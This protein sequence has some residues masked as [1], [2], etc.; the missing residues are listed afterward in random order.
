MVEGT[1]CSAVVAATFSVV[2]FVVGF[3]TPYWTLAEEVMTGIFYR[4]TTLNEGIN[5]EDTLTETT[6]DWMRAVQAL[7]VLALIVGL[8][9]LIVAAIWAYV[10]I[11]YSVSVLFGSSGCGVFSANETSESY[12]LFISCASCLLFLLTAI[13][14]V[15]GACKATGNK[16]Y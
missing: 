9:G 15:I 11:R 13:I 2:L 5:C 8:A 14:A 7:Q 12:S 1:S 3:S 16:V 10:F 4:C 6:P